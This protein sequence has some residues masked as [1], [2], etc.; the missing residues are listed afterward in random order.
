MK[1]TDQEILQ[2]IRNPKSKEKGFRILIEQHQQQIYHTIRKMVYTHEDANDLTQNTFIKVY[3][4]VDG[5]KENAALHTWIYRI[6]INECLSFLKKKKKRSFLSMDTYE[7]HIQS[8]LGYP[9]NLNGSQIE[10][11]LAKALLRLPDKQRLVFNLRYQEELTYEQLSQLTDTSVGALKASY[12][13]AVQKIK[14]I[15]QDE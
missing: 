5:F 14:K 8:Y 7:N 11:K 4:H 6:A 12:H 9:E 2:L 10:A 1:I 15:L 3:H 13:Q